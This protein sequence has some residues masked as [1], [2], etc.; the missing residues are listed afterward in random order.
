M[1]LPV[2]SNA[3]GTENSRTK[4]TE[5]GTAVHRI[6]G[7]AF[8]HRV[9]VLSMKTPT[10]RS[11]TPFNSWPMSRIVPAMAAPTPATVVR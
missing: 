7:L 10:T 1:I 4:L 9:R 8:P 2:S 5:S 6:Q 11:V 3:A